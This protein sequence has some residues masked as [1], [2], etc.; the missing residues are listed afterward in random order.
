MGKGNSDA[1][2]SSLAGEL[3]RLE[4]VPELCIDTSDIPETLD[5]SGSVRGK[6]YS[7]GGGSDT[8]QIDSDI[9]AYF[10]STGPGYAERINR[11]LRASMLRNIRK[12]GSG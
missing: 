2:P 9:L 12:H 11:V 3:R 7:P 1:I 4:A 10:K 6:F 5:W 8:L